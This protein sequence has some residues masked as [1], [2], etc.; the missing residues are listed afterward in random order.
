MFYIITQ[1]PL[2][3]VVPHKFLKFSIKKIALPQGTDMLPSAD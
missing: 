2:C 1:Y 3:K